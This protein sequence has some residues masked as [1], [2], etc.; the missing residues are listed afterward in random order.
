MD[1]NHPL[2]NVLSSDPGNLPDRG[3]LYR[4]LARNFPNGAVILFDRQLRYILADGI[5]LTEI[6]LSSQMLEGKTIWQI[7]PEEVCQVLE[8]RYRAA[9]DGEPSDF[10]VNFA[11]RIYHVHTLPIHDNQGEISTGMVMT[12]DIT[13]RKNAEESL[14]RSQQSYE[15][16]VNSI[17]GIVWEG[18]AQTFQY[19]FVSKQAERLLGYPTER[20]IDEPTF[21][22]DHIHPQDRDWTIN[23]CALS[24]ANK[25]DHVFEYR[26]IA[27]DGR[28]VWLRDIVTVIIE[29]DTPVKL[30][31][32][33]VDITENKKVEADLLEREQQYRSIFE[34]VSDALFINR[35]EDG[36]LVDFNPAAAFMHGY[37]VEEFRNLQP[38]DFIHPD[39]HPIFGEYIKTVQSGRI[40]QGRAVDIRKDGST[41]HVEVLGTLFQYKGIPHTLAIV[42]DIDEQVKSFH[43]LEERVEERTKELQILLDISR[44]VASTLDLDRLMSMIIEQ[45]K[46]VVDF[47]A[48]RVWMRENED[49]FV[50][51]DYLG[52]MPA[53]KN[54][55]RWKQPPHHLAILDLANLQEPFI[56]PNVHVD[57]P[58]AL[59]WRE[60]TSEILGE[61]PAFISSFMVVPLVANKR[62]IGLLS[63]NHQHPGYYTGRHA[64][65]ALAVANHAAAAIENAYLYK[66]SLDLAALQERQKLAREL[67]DSVSQAL[68]GIALGAR[69][70]RK[71]LDGEVINRDDLLKPVEYVLSLAEAG[72]AEMRALIFELRPDSLQNEGLAAALAKQAASLEARHQIRVITMFDEE[73]S[74]TLETKQTLYRIAQEALN[75]IIKH[76]RPSQVELRLTSSAGKVILEIKDDGIGFDVDGLFPG[77]LGLRSMRE[78]AENMGG[79]LVI[80]SIPGKGTRVFVQVP[81]QE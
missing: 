49:T 53:E 4:T 40:F 80:E 3:E 5:G 58:A 68:Y 52:P 67:H 48:L 57:T 21:W 7:F 29:N 56:I 69:T 75:N 32:I 28:V 33:M 59:M 41:F 24:T 22:Q 23:F 45:L 35:L 46:T 62:V 65:L 60:A 11:G 39:S 8:P 27:A 38:V 74:L 18:D 71:L 1:I 31:G 79:E 78:R 50:I 81:L 20:W 76:A 15:Q 37:T 19:F 26:M 6:G 17:D 36:Q 66:N 61:V 55:L 10:E 73:P 72:L 12:Q 16:L 51:K 42:H 63:F 43:L 9:L 54:V 70:A 25:K 30:R 2:G 44:K 34:T 14:L 64:D 47:T 13:G 77:H